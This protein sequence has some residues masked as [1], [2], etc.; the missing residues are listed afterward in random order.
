MLIAL[1]ALLALCEGQSFPIAINE[2]GPCASTTFN[3]RDEVDRLAGAGCDSDKLYVAL[4]FLASGSASRN[5]ILTLGSAYDDALCN[6]SCYSAVTQLIN[7]CFT[8]YIAEDFIDLLDGMCSTNE[9]GVPCYEVVSGYS[10]GP[11]AC[12]ADLQGNGE[13]DECSH[14]CRLQLRQFYLNV[15]CCA[16][17][18]FDIDFTRYLYWRDDT[19]WS[20]CDLNPPSDE[21]TYQS[22][23]GRSRVPD[24]S[25]GQ[26]LAVNV[27][28][29][30]ITTMLVAVMML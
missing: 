8:D 5:T 3:L 2:D 27:L 20:P 9:N 16:R 15:G 21:C 4:S 30:V 14:S 10:G 29:T 18:V 13:L 1:A 26:A 17:N 22:F 25:S 28:L 23:A 6:S 19:I 12:Y 24:V 7:F 11:S